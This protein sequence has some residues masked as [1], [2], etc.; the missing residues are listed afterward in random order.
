MPD[1]IDFPQKDDPTA[2][3]L[4]G[5]YEYWQVVVSGRAIPRLAGRRIADGG[6][7]LIVDD[8]FMGGPFYGETANQ[9]AYLIAQALAIGAEYSN[10][11]ADAKGM[12]FAS[13]LRCLGDMPE[14]PNGDAHV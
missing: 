1:V 11:E 10:L 3:L 2:T 12:P 5:P 7:N 8:R 9:A 4:N 14:T 6:I 13:I